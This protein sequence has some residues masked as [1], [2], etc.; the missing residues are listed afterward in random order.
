MSTYDLKKIFD[1]SIGSTKA[2]FISK[3]Q[4]KYPRLDKKDIET[5]FKSQ[6]VVQINTTVKGVNL[7]ITAKPRTFQIDVMF[8]KIG[9]SLKPF[10]LLVDIM[11]RKAFCYS[12]PGEK[13]MSKI[14]TAY[15]K[16][17][18]NVDY[19]KGIEGDGEFDNTGFKKLNE[20]KGIQVSTS[21]AKDNHFTSGN[22]LGI[23]DRLTRTLKE[24][25][26]K[27]RSSTGT[28][29][30]LQ[31]M[32][33]TVINLY[34]DSPHRG[35]QGKTPNQMWDNTKEQEKRNIVETMSND[36]IFNKLPLAIGDDVRV[37][38]NKDKFDKGNAQFSQEIY[39]IH[40]RVGYSYKVKDAEGS[41]KRRRY[42]PHE[43]LVVDN[44]ANT[45]NMDRKKRD[46]KS[47]SKY[48]T[49]NKLIRNEDMTR[50]EAKKALKGIDANVLGPARNTRSQ[51]KTTRHTNKAVVPTQVRAKTTKRKTLPA[52]DI[53]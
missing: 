20:D 45:M 18:H 23:I 33:D 3:V 10:L 51:D 2:Y 46:E 14:I 5:W 53:G 52:I 21:V 13:N 26:R 39:E 37:L 30:N 27:Y 22:K 43:L 44:V 48:K 50:T 41:V 11:S 19:V 28:L 25:I 42:K 15:N 24:N 4:Q 7:K 36:K 40:D 1:E 49:V 12:I 8:Y 38:E 31:N 16:F 34:N 29:G 6:E 35:I 47:T 9:Q 17:L 32:M